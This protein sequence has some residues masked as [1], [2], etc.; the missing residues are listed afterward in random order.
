MI[1]YEQIKKE[2]GGPI[3]FLII[4]ILEKEGVI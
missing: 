3:E 1:T 2:G 4:R